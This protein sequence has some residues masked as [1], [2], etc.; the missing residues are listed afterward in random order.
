MKYKTIGSQSAELLA[1]LQQEGSEFF[2]LSDALR[3]FGNRNEAS[4]R[5][6]L[7]QMT[8]RGLLMRLRDG[9]FHIIP[10]DRDPAAY[11]P[12]WH[13]VAH[14]LV[15]ETPYYIG[16]YSALVLHDLTTQPALSEQ[17]VVGKPI[18]PG[19][20]EIHGIS[21]RFIYHNPAHFFG[22]SKKWVQGIYRVQ[23]SDLEKTMID[24][25]FNPALGGGVVELS[26]AL[27]KSKEQLNGAKL[28]DYCERFST[29][30]VSRR[31]GFLLENLDIL[32]E[33][34][35]DLQKSIPKNA[36]FVRLD[37]GLPKSGKTVSRWGIIQNTDLTDIQNI[38]FN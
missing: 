28:L 24:C 33:I 9:L 36:T 30:A 15:G 13:L 4:L 22:F 37:N 38:L 34:S 20:Q 5:N 35:Q 12:D 31:L 19:Q 10:Y 6:L 29:D 32:P 18:R 25:A 3:V 27:W 16:Y 14:H 8:G 21:F 11:F 26:K 17:V 2:R 1:A 23:C 7:G